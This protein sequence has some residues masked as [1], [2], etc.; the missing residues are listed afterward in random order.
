MSTLALLTQRFLYISGL[1]PDTTPDTVSQIL[2]HTRE[3]NRA[4]A[5]SGALV[6]DGERFCQLIEGPPDAVHAL[7]SRIVQDPRHVDLRVLLDAGDA[8]PRLLQ[9]WQTGYCE[10]QRLDALDAAAP[11]APAQALALF[12]ELLADCDLSH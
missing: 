4:R 12:I 5:I 8:T 7:A 2:R 6:F 10:P 9:P 11:M 3:R 1:A